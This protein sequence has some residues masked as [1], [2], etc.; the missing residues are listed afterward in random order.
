MSLCKRC[1]KDE[2]DFCLRCKNRAVSDAENE[3]YEKRPKV[4]REFVTRWAE[5]F[6]G[7]ITDTRFRW[8][9]IA[10][11]REAGVKVEEIESEI[12]EKQ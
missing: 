5:V 10:M 3:L 2:A 6:H 1:G 4:S 9:I 11:L 12:K 7:D 8:D